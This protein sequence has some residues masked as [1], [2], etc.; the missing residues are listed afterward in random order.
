MRLSPHVVRVIDYLN[1]VSYIPT[2]A[3]IG[4]AVGLSSS[5]VWRVL[6]N[7]KKL[8]VEFKAVVDLGRL[9]LT[10]VL[11]VYKSRLPLDRV[12]KKLIRS[13]IRTLEGATF[14]K[15]VT[16]VHEVESTVNYVIASLDQ[17][18]SEVYVLDTI[19]PPRYVL[20]HITRS[21]LDRL[22]LREL[23]AVASLP[24]FL[25]K[26]SVI[27]RLDSID[28]LLANKLEENAL[29]KI[30]E[31]HSVVKSSVM[32]CSYQTFLKHF[33]KH[34]LERDVIIGIRPTIENY[35]DRVTPAVRKLLVLYGVP[36]F[37]LKGVKAIIAI[38]GFTEAYL[39]TREGIAYVVSTLPVGLIPKVVDFLG[40]LESRDLI[41]GWIIL[42]ID[43]ASILRL[44]LSE[45]L[46]AMSAS[47]LLAKASG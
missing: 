45:D 2:I 16:R 40:I 34:I 46:G 17:E 24:Q 18:P 42:E 28:I 14:L 6:N 12:P 10:E 15:Y 44:P 9:G 31:V 43:S 30:K 32:A 4:S 13:F 23:M 21:T 26:K 22:Y 27:S 11:L 37:L 5:T 41:R 1:S 25:G 47:E 36:N 33:R 8:G 38:P 35:I 7:L 19:V 20:S 29:A 3:E 39:S